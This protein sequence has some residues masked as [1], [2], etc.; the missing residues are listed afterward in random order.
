ML[1]NG[2]I[3]IKFDTYGTPYL[4]VDKF[5]SF[6]EQSIKELNNELHPSNPASQE[7]STEDLFMTQ[8]AVQLLAG[9]G[10]EITELLLFTYENKTFHKEI[11][12]VEEF[13]DFIE[14]DQIN[15]L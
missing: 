6:L 7:M 2:S 9:L 11:N 1:A 12:T 13:L 4:D 10:H 5:L 15:E 14:Q 3:P 8:G